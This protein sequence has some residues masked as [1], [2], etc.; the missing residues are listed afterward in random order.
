VIRIDHVYD[1][2]ADVDTA[3][4]VIVDPE[5]YEDVAVRSKALEHSA[6][7]TLVHQVHTITLERSMPTDQVPSFAKSLV[8]DA[9][10]IHETTWWKAGSPDDGDADGYHATFS[11]QIVGTPVTFNGSMR[12]TSTETGSRQS[13]TGDI[14]AAIPF[15]GGKVESSIKEPVELQIAAVA[16]MVTERLQG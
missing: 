11:V 4:S 15:L 12:L 6:N 13:V 2:P 1:Y 8:G 10:R 7:V 16:R 9:L 14:K 3:F 5:L